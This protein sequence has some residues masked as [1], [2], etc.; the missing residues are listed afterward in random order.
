MDL[1]DD[2]RGA[3][4]GRRAPARPGRRNTGPTSQVPAQVTVRPHVRGHPASRATAAPSHAVAHRT[5]AAPASSAP[6]PARP[7][8]PPA[9]AGPTHP[10]RRP[11]RAL[12]VPTVGP[13]RRHAQRHGAVAK[14]DAAW[15]ARRQPVARLVASGAAA[16]VLPCAAAGATAPRD[17]VPPASAADVPD[18]APC[19]PAHWLSRIGRGSPSGRRDAISRNVAGDPMAARRDESLVPGDRLRAARHR[20]NVLGAGQPLRGVDRQHVAV[21]EQD[22]SARR[23]AHVSHFT[24]PS[25]PWAFCNV[26]PAAPMSRTVR[27]RCCR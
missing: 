9:Q 16:R 25:R 18:C 5:G 7:L 23:V 1:V 24:K 11:V 15:L 17:R 21:A 19:W 2:V 13:G 4:R 3:S 6:L 27:T 14:H 8:A 26:M 10:K 20:L 22:A 12:D